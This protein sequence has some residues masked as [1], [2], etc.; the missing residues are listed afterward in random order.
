[1]I[2]GEDRSKIQRLAQ[3]IACEIEKEIGEGSK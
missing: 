2:E 3:D 1:M